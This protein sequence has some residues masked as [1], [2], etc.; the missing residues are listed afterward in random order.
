LLLPRLLQRRLG[1]LALHF[2]LFMNPSREPQ[3]PLVIFKPIPFLLLKPV[4]LLQLLL[5]VKLVLLLHRLKPHNLLVVFV[6]L[7]AI[8]DVH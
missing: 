2:P 4:P 3:L 5:L 6:R 8:L 1:S 7:V